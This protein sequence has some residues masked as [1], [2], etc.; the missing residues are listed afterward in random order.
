[1]VINKDGAK[2]KNKPVILV[3]DDQPQNIE[4]LEAYLVPQGY[5]IV[6]AANGREALG[7]LSGN[8]I[9]LIL[10]DVKMPGMD[11]FEVTRRVREDAQNHLLPIV[12]VTALRETEDRV[13]GIEAGCD[14]FLTKPVDKMELL[15]RI[16]S[17]LK[18]KDYNDQKELEIIIKSSDE[19]REYAESI[20]NT[21]REPLISLDQD[22]RVVT[23]N[24]SFYEVFKVKPENTMG[25]LIYDLGNKQWNIPKLRELLETIL[26]QKTTFVNYEVEHDFATIGRR[27]MLL[28]ARQI[29]RVLG[30]ERI[31]LLTIED[32]TER[33]AS[34]EKLQ[35]AINERKKIE[36]TLRETNDYLENLFNYA[37]APIIVWDTQLRIT[38]FNP[39]FESLT[40][41][42]H[43]EVIGQSIE[44]LFPPSLVVS[45]MDLIRA[46]T[47]G[48][49]WETVEIPILRR[50]GTIRTLLWN[51]ATVF[52]ADGKTPVSTIA[53]GHD[54]TLR[55]QA[56]DK[57]KQTTA[58]LTRSNEELQRFAY[59]ASHDLQEPL[60]MV[61]S[62]V[63]LLERRY[64][65]KLDDDASE[66]INFAVEGTK[67]MQ[68]LIND[69]LAYSRVDSQGKPFEPVNM[70]Q[71]LGYTLANL[72]VAVEESH[73]IVTHDLLPTVIGD[74]GQMVQ[75]FQNLVANAIK[76][77]GKE[78]PRVHISAELKENEWVFSVKDN[79]IGI[80]PQYFDRIFII[81]QRLHG[82]EYPGTGT[83]LSIVKRI[84]ERHGGRVWVESEY[85]KNT[86]FYFSI[87]KRGGT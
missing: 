7:K 42:N 80:E 22:L 50:D 57:L 53:Q 55:K 66:F 26:P 59:V 84:V 81:F 77:H 28:N 41:R 6:K 8:K 40:G 48:K 75:V 79:G 2:Q 85:N 63:Q 37:N 24:R 78:A 10:L 67:R 19:A 68:N 56:V 64:K 65:D 36:E 15:A 86:T 9:D 33:K 17:L 1:M 69:L 82:Q 25:Q 27:V 52:A 70:E 71:I 20:I 38:R 32:I 72:E 60:R 74:E 76:F 13:K 29:Q 35:G 21:M 5:Q 12:L 16:K 14:D 62:Y 46:T 43:G 44:M 49:R 23:A 61:A 34:D 39:A 47:G 45:S 31:I 87:P 30:K 54:I 58:E 73:T 18:V 11:G 83:G 3:V 51:S 4:L